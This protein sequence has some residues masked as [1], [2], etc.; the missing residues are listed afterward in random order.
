MMSLPII[1]WTEEELF[2]YSKGFSKRTF[3]W[4]DLLSVE[5]DVNLVTWR[6]SNN[7]FVQLRWSEISRFDHGRLQRLIEIKSKNN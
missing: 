5:S 1:S 6:F 7:G 4:R 3:F 2:L